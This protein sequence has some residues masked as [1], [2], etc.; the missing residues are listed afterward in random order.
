MYEMN[1][2]HYANPSISV[3]IAK[4][5]FLGF[6]VRDRTYMCSVLTTTLTFMTYFSLFTSMASVKAEDVHASFLFVGVLNGHHQEWL[7]STITNHHSV[8]ASDFAAVWL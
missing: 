1:I 3:V 5:C 6:V 8:A 4:C 2:E 7:G